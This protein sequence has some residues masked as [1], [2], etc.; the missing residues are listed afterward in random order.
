MIRH[1]PL[2][3]V[4]SQLG[5]QAILAVK[6]QDGRI[7]QLDNFPT[8]QQYVG[9]SNGMLQGKQREAEYQHRSDHPSQVESKALCLLPPSEKEPGQGG[10]QEQSAQRNVGQRHPRFGTNAEIRGFNRRERR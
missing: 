8:E 5:D 6:R 9:M 4:S 3:L 2:S 10:D 7:M 1:R